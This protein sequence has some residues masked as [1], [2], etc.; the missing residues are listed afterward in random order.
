MCQPYSFLGAA[1]I[2]REMFGEFDF[3]PE[4]VPSSQN[5]EEGGE[6]ENTVLSFQLNTLLEC[7]NIFGTAFGSSSGPP[8]PRR[9]WKND[10]AGEGED[11][12]QAPPNGNRRPANAGQSRG[13]DAYFSRADGKGTGM[14]L[15]YGGA[16]HP[17]R[18]LLC[19]IH[20]E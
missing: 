13:I 11:E 14:R 12:Q 6:S 8:L 18:L 9:R 16:G 3:R 1:C 5:D 15:S 4:S 7:L 2:A 19:V 20:I 10:E 17:L